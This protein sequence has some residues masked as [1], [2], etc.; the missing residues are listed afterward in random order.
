M[1][2]RVLDDVSGSKL[3]KTRTL[4]PFVATAS[5]LLKAPAAE[6]GFTISKAGVPKGYRPQIAVDVV[7]SSARDPTAT[8]RLP[9]T[10]ASVT[11]S[12]APGAPPHVLSSQVFRFTAT[13]C[14]PVAPTSH[15]APTQS[16]LVAARNPWGT[17][18]SDS[19]SHTPVESSWC[20]TVWYPSSGVSRW[21]KTVSVPAASLHASRTSSN[22]AGQ[23]RSRV[24]STFN[25]ASK[26]AT[27]PRRRFDSGR[28]VEDTKNAPVA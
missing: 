28:T 10:T 17:S 22:T 15:G 20:S 14:V 18:G 12:K 11:S 1:L 7:S 16:T 19:P 6:S 4:L 24:Q 26:C 13:G 27:W 3:C 21:V 9:N 5:A 25:S 23:G 8:I 2:W